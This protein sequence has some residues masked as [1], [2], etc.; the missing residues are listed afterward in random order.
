MSFFSLFIIGSLNWIREMKEVIITWAKIKLGARVQKRKE[1]KRGKRGREIK[2][3]LDMS[4][5]RR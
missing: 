4:A 2:V 5:E 3:F 1:K